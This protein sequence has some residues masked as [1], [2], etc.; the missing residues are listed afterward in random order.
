[1][2]D[3]KKMVFNENNIH[4]A[5]NWLA[6]GNLLAYPTESV[7]GIGCDPFNQQAV[8]DLLKLKQRPMEKGLIV[9]TSD[10]DTITD[11][12]T[13]L[14]SQN[15]Q[16]IMQT[17]ESSDITQATTWLFPIPNNLPQPIPDWVTGGRDT[18]AIRV[19]THPM[20]ATLCQTLISPQNPYGFLVSTSC[21]P[22]TKPPATTLAQAQGYFGEHKNVSY[23][24]AP[25]LHFNQPSQIRDAVTGELVR[26]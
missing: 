5:C 13:Q 22:S 15:Q 23:F 3:V 6:T 19:M 25:T 9:I 20:I 14:T 10:S 18:L 16:Q 17:W 7:W 4:Q 2:T 1:M 21:N 26:E 24:N 11:F 8:F 12:L